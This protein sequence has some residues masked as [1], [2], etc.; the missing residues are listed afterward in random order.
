[1]S[2]KAPHPLL[3]TLIM[4]RR[5]CLSCL[6]ARA[7]MSRVAVQAS[8]DVLGRALP[9]NRYADKRCDACGD[10]TGV[11]MVGAR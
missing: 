9:V 7:G 11:F 10:R 5:M 8:L 2:R 4:D 1:M 3:S 6:A